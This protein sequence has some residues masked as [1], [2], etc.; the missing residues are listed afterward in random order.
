MRR[1]INVTFTDEEEELY[2]W[3]METSKRHGGISR[4]IKQLLWIWYKGGNAAAEVIASIEDKIAEKRSRAGKSRKKPARSSADYICG[5][6]FATMVLMA[7]N[8]RRRVYY[9]PRCG[10]T[11]AVEAR[12]SE[13]GAAEIG[14][15]D[16]VKLF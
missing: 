3:L 15:E 9:C 7:K 13:G 14:E 6:C 12:A 11:K 2:R 8:R 1:Q 5:N 16:S 10:L 4:F